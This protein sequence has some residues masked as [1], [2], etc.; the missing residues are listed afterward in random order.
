MADGRSKLKDLANA[1]EKR[2][3]ILRC[4]LSKLGFESEGTNGDQN[5]DS[6]APED[7]EKH[8]RLVRTNIGSKQCSWSS[9][10]SFA[11]TITKKAFG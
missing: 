6:A 4:R 9:K 7:Q 10:C 5:F 8:K 2:H 1:F 11:S 3:E